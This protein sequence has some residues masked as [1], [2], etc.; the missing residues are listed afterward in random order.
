[1]I[2]RSDVT[3]T[4]TYILIN[5]HVLAANENMFE[6]VRGTAFSHT[7]HWVSRSSLITADVDENDYTKATHATT[8]YRTVPCQRSLLLG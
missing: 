8:Q 3:R 1:M 2:Q 4:H 7:I 6:Q 5:N